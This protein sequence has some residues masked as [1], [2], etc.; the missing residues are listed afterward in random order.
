MS[1]Y[2]DPRPIALIPTLAELRDQVLLRSTKRCPKWKMRLAAE[3]VIELQPK[4]AVLIADIARTYGYQQHTVEFNGQAYFGPNLT[5][6][7]LT[8]PRG[9]RRPFVP[10][11]KFKIF[12]IEGETVWR[13]KPFTGTMQY[14]DLV[15]G[16]AMVTVEAAPLLD[17]LCARLTPA[18][19]A[20]LPDVMLSPQC[21]ICGKRLTDPASM[22]RFIGPECFGSSTLTVPQTLRLLA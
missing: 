8:K 3:L 18:T 5:A 11:I 14:R 22:A 15:S 7:T 12:A 10:Q 19:F 2:W 6:D 13:V 21:M 20:V 9:V 17:H 16:S 4:P 1:T